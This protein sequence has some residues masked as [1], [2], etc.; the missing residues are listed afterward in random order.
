MGR[1]GSFKIFFKN[2]SIFIMQGCL[3]TLEYFFE[4]LLVPCIKRNTGIALK[5]ER[6]VSHN[7]CERL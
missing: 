7:F 6:A 4:F 5:W 1:E 2:A 3:I